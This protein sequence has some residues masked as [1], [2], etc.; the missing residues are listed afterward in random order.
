MSYTGDSDPGPLHESP[1]KLPNFYAIYT[2]YELFPILSPSLFPFAHGGNSLL[3]LVSSLHILKD[4]L[5]QRNCPY[6]IL[7]M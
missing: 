7:D 3:I 1:N 4:L 2:K 6:S 5:D